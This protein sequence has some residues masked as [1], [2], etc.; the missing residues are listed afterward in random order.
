[1]CAFLVCALSF[2]LQPASSGS[3][4]SEVRCFINPKESTCIEG[5]RQSQMGGTGSPAITFLEVPQWSPSALEG[6][7]F[8]TMHNLQF[9][10]KSRYTI[11]WPLSSCE[12]SFE[13][14]SMT[15]KEMLYLNVM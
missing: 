1:M 6:T 5:K 10:L 15:V 4:C 3:L 7:F 12:L 11:Q 14:F 2:R 8:L 13:H 9:L